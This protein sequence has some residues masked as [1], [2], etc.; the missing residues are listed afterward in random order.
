MNTVSTTTLSQREANTTAFAQTACTTPWTRCSASGHV[1]SRC[2]GQTLTHLV[3]DLQQVV[4][5]EEFDAQ[6]RIV[7]PNA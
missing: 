6:A 3:L 4:G 1:T 7:A 2:H 5:I